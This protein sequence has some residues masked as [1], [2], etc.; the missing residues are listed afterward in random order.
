MARTSRFTV[1]QMSDALTATKGLVHITAKQLQ[2]DPQTVYNYINKYDEVRRA[3]TNAREQM[4]DVAELRFFEAINNREPWAIAMMLKT[5]GKHRGYI[6]SKEFVLK[7]KEA[8]QQI[9][10][11]LGIYLVD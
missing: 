11:D 3:L 4:I 5:R 1:K 10:E 9:A 7:Q 8:R 2:C 6:E